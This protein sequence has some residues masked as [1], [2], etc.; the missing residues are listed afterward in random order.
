M[1]N[2]NLAFVSEYSLSQQNTW[3]NRGLLYTACYMHL[4]LVP[5]KCHTMY[6]EA[7]MFPHYHTL[8]PI[9]NAAFVKK[10]TNELPQNYGF[11]KGFIY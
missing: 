8:S 1:L 5:V 9:L 7:T 11:P 2:F 10:F 6:V 3:L 4:L